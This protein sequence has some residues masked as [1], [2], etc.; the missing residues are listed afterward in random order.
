MIKMMMAAAGLSIG[1][2][3]TPVAT[4]PAKAGINIDI[5]VEGQGGRISCNRGRK[6]VQNSG[7]WDVRARNC[8]GR[9]YSYFG[10][11]KNGR[12]FVITVDAKRAYITDVR[13][14]Y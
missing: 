6:I 12:A 13:R 4:A 8:G 5:N 14:I 7:Y 1:L 3:M 10:R 11:K 9:Y 2:L